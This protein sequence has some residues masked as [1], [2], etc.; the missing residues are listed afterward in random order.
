M[1]D[2]EIIEQIK[3]DL[4]EP[5]IDVYTPDKSIQSFIN[6]G[7]ELLRSWVYQKVTFVVPCQSINRLDKEKVRIVIDVVPYQLTGTTDGNI[8]VYYA[9]DFSLATAVQYYN[10]YNNNSVLT[11]VLAAMN[12]NQ[13]NY[14]FNMQF[15]WKYDD[16]TGELY[17]THIPDRAQVLVVKAKTIYER[18]TLDPEYDAWL[19][20]FAEGQ[21]KITEGRIRS[22]YKEGSVGA[23]S[24][25]DQL[26]QEGQAEVQAC[27]DEIQSFVPMDVG[28]RA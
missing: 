26:I 22:K 23:T 27:M 17:V 14:A 11:P 28:R 9:D 25:G 2:S 16:T 8:P 13:L 20:K 18:E 5:V 7:L 15:D 6:K 12:Y 10:I 21:T 19:L 24:D 3:M 1:T 4:G